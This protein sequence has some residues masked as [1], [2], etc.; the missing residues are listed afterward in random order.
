MTHH[1][2]HRL[3]KD[4]LAR[5]SHDIDVKEASHTPR[6]YYAACND[7]GWRSPVGT[8]DEADKALIKHRDDTVAAAQRQGGGRV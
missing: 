1:V 8:G 6:E 5:G 7:C 3:V 2:I 4:Y